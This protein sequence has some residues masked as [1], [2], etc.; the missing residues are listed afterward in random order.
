MEYAN[1]GDLQNYLGNNFD[2]LT[3]SDKI[4]LAFQIADGLYYLHDRNILHRDLH[5]KN[6]LI[7]ENNVKITDFGLSKYQYTQKS[8]AYVGN[9]GVIAYI[10]PKRIFDRNFLYTESSDIYS[11]GVIMWEISSGCP[12]FKDYSNRIELAAFIK[13]GIREETIPDTPIEYEELYKNCWS[14]KPN[15]RPTISKIIDELRKMAITHNKL[16]PS[17]FINFIIDYKVVK[18]INK[19]ELSDMKNI[20]GGHFGII[21]K[22]KWIKTNNYVICTQKIKK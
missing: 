11:F 14:E 5:S 22:A 16:E 12:P 2:K 6:I 10:E 18:V 17:E 13:N 1:G 20:D 21:S 19:S 15:Q 8:T 4:R 9:F 7:H 3:W